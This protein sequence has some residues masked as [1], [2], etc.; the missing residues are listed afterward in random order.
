MI[1][2]IKKANII[3]EIVKNIGVKIIYI[4]V[5]LNLINSQRCE[6]ISCFLAMFFN[7]CE[8]NIGLLKLFLFLNWTIWHLFN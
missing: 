8:Y 3:A 7:I 4:H 5:S 2:I 1:Q 6:N